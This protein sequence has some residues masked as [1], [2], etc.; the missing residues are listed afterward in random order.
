MTAVAICVLAMAGLAALSP[1]SAV[2]GPPSGLEHDRQTMSRELARHQC[3]QS[4]VTSILKRTNSSPEVA[5]AAA[6][7]RCGLLFAGAPEKITVAKPRDI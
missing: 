6:E 1:L 7:R 2:F 3:E 4:L 5:S